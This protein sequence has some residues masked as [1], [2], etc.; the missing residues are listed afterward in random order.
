MIRQKPIIGE[1]GNTFS[2]YHLSFVSRQTFPAG[3]DGKLSI[4]DAQASFHHRAVWKSADGKEGEYKFAGTGTFHGSGQFVGQ[5]L[6]L[7]LTWTSGTGPGKANG[8]LL[9]E[10]AGA[11]SGK[12]EWTLKPVTMTVRF[13]SG[14]AK[15]IV[16]YA[17]SRRSIMPQQLAGCPPLP[18]IER[19]EVYRLPTADLEITSRANPVSIRPGGGRTLKVAVKNVGPDPAH[20][21]ELSMLLPDGARV[22]SPAEYKNQLAGLQ[23]LA[24]ALN[25]LAKGGKVDVEIQYEAAADEPIDMIDAEL[26]TLVFVSSASYDPNHGNNGHFDRTTLKAK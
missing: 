11:H 6:N 1:N 9:D 25:D 22:I 10:T 20:G 15:E 7:D 18:R 19:V 12:S 23:P 3:N 26:I 4:H 17:G 24:I 13:G 21:V 2:D 16:G 5:T 14:D 8:Q